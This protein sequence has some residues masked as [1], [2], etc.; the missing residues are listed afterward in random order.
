M[1]VKMILVVKHIYFALCYQQSSRRK[2]ISAF[3]FICIFQYMDRFSCASFSQRSST[4]TFHGAPRVWNGA[5]IRKT[6]RGDSVLYIILE[7]VQVC[8]CHLTQCIMPGVC[9]LAELRSFKHEFF[10]VTQSRKL[11]FF[12]YINLSAR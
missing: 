3:K 10:C 7:D 6:V 1:K 5:M 4:F 12:I 2:W 11:L 8:L 9:S